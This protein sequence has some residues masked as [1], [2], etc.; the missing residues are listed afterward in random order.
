MSIIQSRVNTASEEFQ[1]NLEHHEKL[2]E[3]L[4][5]RLIAVAEQPHFGHGLGA[6]GECVVG[7]EAGSR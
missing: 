1:S 2:K 5:E 4:Q 6:G 3:E 7:G